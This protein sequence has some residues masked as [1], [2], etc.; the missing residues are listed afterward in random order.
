MS[1]NVEIVVARLE[2]ALTAHMEADTQALNQMRIEN[3]ELRKLVEELHRKLDKQK[4]FTGGVIF[5]AS[6][7]ITAVWA[8]F[9][10]LAHK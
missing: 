2:V 9:T 6:A 3:T 10:F 1:E 4:S 7:I 8:V 5:A